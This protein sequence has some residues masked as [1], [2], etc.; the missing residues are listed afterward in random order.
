MNQ[1][2]KKQGQILSPS[3][4]KVKKT[5]LSLWMPQRCVVGVEVYL[6]SLLTLTLDTG[7]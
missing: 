1:Y 4:C 7:E 3:K 6:P 5:K 2:V